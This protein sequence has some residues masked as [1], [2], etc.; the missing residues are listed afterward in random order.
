MLVVLSQVTGLNGLCIKNKNFYHFR[1]WIFLV[2]VVTP[3]RDDLHKV[4]LAGLTSLNLS[5]VGANK[6]FHSLRS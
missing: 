2:G 1:D 5:G 6:S 4:G 3:Q